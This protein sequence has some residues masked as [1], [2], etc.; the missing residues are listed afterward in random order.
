MSGSSTRVKP[1]L[2]E[3]GLKQRKVKTI[4]IILDLGAN[5]EMFGAPREGIKTEEHI[6]LATWFKTA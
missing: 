5:L 6:K 4:M 3:S 1:P 2:L